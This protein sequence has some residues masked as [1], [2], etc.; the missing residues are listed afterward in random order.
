M[1]REALHFVR[2]VPAAL[3]LKAR[4]SQAE[5]YHE[6]M[7]RAEQAGMSDRRA[8]LVA[9]LRGEVLEIGS[10]TGLMFAHYAPDT[11]V[12]AIEPDDSFRDISLAPAR[13]AVAEIDVMTADATRLPFEAGRFDAV[14]DALVLCS[15]ASMETVL[16][17][18]HRVLRPGGTLRMIE[19]VRSEGRVAGPL[20]SAINPLWL[21]LNAQGCNMNRQPHKLLARA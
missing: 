19:H 16:A 5:L 1:L 18:V 6:L 20:M 14:V 21:K 9:D 12:T 15:V 8:D 13:A 17:E 4:L 10:G 7:R 2:H 11:H 3:R